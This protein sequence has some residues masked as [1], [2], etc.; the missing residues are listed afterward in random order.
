M[1]EYMNERWKASILFG[2]ISGLQD[3]FYESR[4]AFMLE[5]MTGRKH[6]VQKESCQAILQAGLLARKLDF[7]Q[8][9]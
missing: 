3:G 5:G 6:S 9:S 1:T 7:H 8:E 4:L 2:L